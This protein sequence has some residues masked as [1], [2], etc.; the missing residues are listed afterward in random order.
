MNPIGH[1]GP[2]ASG[3]A[4]AVVRVAE[5]HLLL[6][7]EPMVETI[8]LRVK[9]VAAHLRAQVVVAAVGISGLV[10]MRVKLQVLLRNGADSAGIDYV[11]G[12]GCPLDP[13]VSQFGR[14]SRVVDLILVAER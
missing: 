10:R 1:A 3:F 5:E 6:A 13:A 7:R 2:V 9:I 12:D 14:T 4:P 8:G 11:P